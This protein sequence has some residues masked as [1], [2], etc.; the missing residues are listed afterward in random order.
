MIKKVAIVA[1]ECTP[2]QGSECALG[3][4]LP[5]AIAACRPDLQV[6]VFATPGSWLNTTKY[7][8]DFHRYERLGNK[9]PS[10]IEFS[11]IS[12]PFYSKILAKLN[13]SFSLLGPVGLSP[14]F[15]QII[16]SW[17]KKVIKHINSDDYDLIHF[18]TPISLV[19]YDFKEKVKKPY[20]IG[21]T[22]GITPLNQYSN[23]LTLKTK[24]I[25]WVRSKYLSILHRKLKRGQFFQDCKS[26]I[27]FDRREKFFLNTT[28]TI[29][30][31]PD[32]AT[33]PTKF[34]QR[35]KAYK[36]LK[37]LCVGQITAR[38]Q[39]DIIIE[40]LIQNPNL[41]EY[42]DVEIIGDGPG[43]TSLQSQVWDNKL[44]AHVKFSKAVPYQE[45]QQKYRDA[46]LLVH[47][48][49]REACTHV[50]PEA[51][52]NGLIIICHDVGGISQFVSAE[53]GFLIKLI[54]REYSILEL[55]KILIKLAGREDLVRMK[56][57]SHRISGS[58]T[59]N[60]QAKRVLSF[61]EQICF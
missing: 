43:F 57:V 32:S 50:V 51:I 33:K 40:V 17:R 47:M 49:Y 42:F 3:W 19:S 15:F 34:V 45:L 46:D 26:Y 13:K 20:L 58:F 53:N 9:I 39:N 6:I 35:N 27:L 22:G 10:N 24:L 21:P 36:K 48:S 11:Y 14:L 12:Y 23:S 59:Y 37:I 7:I 30:E 4:N 16:K 5:I 61:Y 56:E 44:E 60:E 8:N 31:L 54:N 55:N 38:K 25:E 28:K 2:F 41:C 29:I 18:L 52:A 1:A